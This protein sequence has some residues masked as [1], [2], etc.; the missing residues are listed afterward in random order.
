VEHYAA[1]RHLV[2][3]ACDLLFAMGVRVMT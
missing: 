2:C 3:D 1:Y